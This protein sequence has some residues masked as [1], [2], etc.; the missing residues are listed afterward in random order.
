MDS[1]KACDSTVGVTVAGFCQAC[2]DSLLS[3]KRR[4]TERQ[5]DNSGWILNGNDHGIADGIR[6]LTVDPGLAN[7]LHEHQKEGARFIYRNSFSDCS[8]FDMS[9]R[10]SDIKYVLLALLLV[11]H[12]IYPT[13]MTNTA[14]AFFFFVCV[15]Y[16]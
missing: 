12:G 6:K 4:K 8:Y 10:E 1:C 13:L 16:I 5:P 2:L 11:S 9:R 14:L 7:K 3:S 15:I